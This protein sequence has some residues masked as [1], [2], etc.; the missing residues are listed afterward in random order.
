MLNIFK[1]RLIQGPLAGYSCAPFRALATYWGQPDFCYSEMLSAQHIYSGAQQ[2]KR[3][4]YKSPKE[5]LLCVQLASDKP[6]ELVYA[7]KKA[8]NEWG[9]NLIDLNCGCP[10]PKIRKKYLGSRLLEDSERINTLVKTLKQNISV[11]VIVKIRVDHQS[12]DGFNKEV[13]MAIALAGADAITVH[14]RHWT[15][16]Y[17]VPV[18]YK[19]IAQIKDLVK[20][21]VIGNGD[22]HN[23]ESARKM[24]S[25]TG[26][27]AVMISRASVGQPWLFEQIY[28]GLQ[29]S[30][31]TIPHLGKIGEIFL[32]HVRG[33][34]E[35]EG[36]KIAILQSRKLG[37]YYARH[38]FDT[39][40]FLRKMNQVNNYQAL[41]SLV[42]EYFS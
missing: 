9:A 31:Y 39:I 21:P 18:S 2:R 30:S 34:I 16:D 35:L 5:D 27:D 19:D 42:R 1:K 10:Q 24:F 33:L 11:P 3:Y 32:E 37:K 12:D 29:G 15:E 4:A 38:H 25:E 8:V 22:I 26:C 28:Q 20:I 6:D 17:D 41:H 40:D 36:E 13:A 7:A 14:G 23:T